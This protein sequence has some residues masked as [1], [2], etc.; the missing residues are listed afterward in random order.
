MLK[1][2]TRR[3]QQ[4][5]RDLYNGLRATMPAARRR[6]ADIMA[7]RAR[8]QPLLDALSRRGDLGPD[9]APAYANVLVDG[10]WDNPNYWTRYACIRAALGLWQG[11]ET[12][13]IGEHSRARARDIFARFGI[14]EVADL[15]TLRG[16][17]GRYRQHARQL[18]QDVRSPDDLMAL[19]LPEGFPAELFYDG[20]LTRQR[21]GAGDPDD[22]LLVDY[23][24]ETLA[25]LAAARE[26]IDRGG[27][28]LVLLSH[29]INYDFS[30]LAWCAMQAG[31]PIII[32]YGDFGTV[33]FIRIDRAE[34]FFFYINRPSVAE[35]EAADPAI[36]AKRLEA[37]TRYLTERLAGN[38]E[39]PGA[40]FAYRQR[41]GAIDRAALA[42][43]YGWDPE[44]PVICVYGAN[45]FDFPH[46]VEMTNFRDFQEW[47][48]ETLAVARET[49]G[50]NW[51]F[52][53][54][55]CDDWYPSSLGPS[56][57]ALVDAVDT[58]NVALASKEWNGRAI[59]DMIDAG[60][61]YFGTIGIELPSIG[62][63]VMVADRGW[64]GEH[65][66]VHWPGDRAAYLEALRHP[67]WRDHDAQT[68]SRAAREFAGWYFALPDWHGDYLF[69]DDSEQEVIYDGLADFVQRYEDEIAREIVLI[70]DW[71]ADGHR[72][73]Q[74]YKM[75]H[76]GRT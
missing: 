21:R 16:N 39:D 33:R 7:R 40:I 48:E 3:M 1:A 4:G 71:V 27:F 51:L 11:R 54:H 56:F 25:N 64:Y 44:T 31:I 46:S 32:L 17:I 18:L 6:E 75:L 26:L 42:E 66:F 38:S 52:K 65:G 67:W 23:L 63:P 68:A 29:A 19:E 10:M 20:L 74:V 30:A 76:E 35:I 59:M 61:T 8:V 12:G 37:G 41:T 49:P 58:P 45:W 28:D 70:R 55:P 34:D 9:G 13:L 2:Q 47:I 50:V 57:G 5:A 69:P 60:I 72:F 73:Y 62:T 24:A 36:R 15:I 43:R 14:D 53:A 22:P